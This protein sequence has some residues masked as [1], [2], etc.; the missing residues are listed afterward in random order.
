MPWARFS[1]TDVVWKQYRARDSIASIT[2]ALSLSRGDTISC[3]L[4]SDSRVESEAATAAAAAIS[5]ALFARLS[6]G[7]SLPPT[8]TIG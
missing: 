2:L 4:K 6:A 1:F 5:Q 7:D 3:R 8:P